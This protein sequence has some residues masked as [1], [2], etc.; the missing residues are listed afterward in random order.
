[1]RVNVVEW[2]RKLQ[3]RRMAYFNRREST[4]WKFK[5]KIRVQERHIKG[6]MTSIGPKRMRPGTASKSEYK[7]GRAK[8][9]VGRLSR[10]QIVP[11]NV[12]RRKGSMGFNLEKGSGTSEEGENA[13]ACGRKQA[14]HACGNRA[15]LCAS[16]PSSASTSD[17][18]GSL[19]CAGGA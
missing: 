3:A 6:H 7:K 8:L 5:Q 1:M 18:A 11:V 10:E 15:T 16:T 9:Y 2:Y 17:C 19:D 12:R 4:T 14:A 13:H